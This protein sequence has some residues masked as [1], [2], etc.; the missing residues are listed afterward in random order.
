MSD[1]FIDVKGRITILPHNKMSGKVKVIAV[2]NDEISS[3]VNIKKPN[4][5]PSSVSIYSDNV[6]INP[7]FPPTFGSQKKANVSI[8]H[9]NE[10]RSNIKINAK[11]RMTG[12]VDITPPPKKTIKLFPV[13]DAFVRE[14]IPTLNYGTEQSMAVGYNS[15]FNESY[16]ALIQFDI[17][18]LPKDIII[19]KA[20]VNLFS[21]EIKKTSQQLGIFTLQAEWNEIGVTWNNQPNISDLLDIQN[22]KDGKISFDITNETKNW[23]D[24]SVSNNGLEIKAVNET[25]NEYVQFNTRENPIDK[26]YLEITYRDKTI[27][28]FGRSEV[29]SKVFIYAVGKSDLKASVRIKSFDEAS[30]I[31]AKVHILNPMFME[32]NVVISKPDL[33]SNVTIRQSGESTISGNVTIR[34]KFFSNLRSS[35]SINAPDR[36]GRVTIPYRSQVNGNVVIRG[37][38]KHDIPAKISISRDTVYASLQIRQKGTNEVTAS[39]TINRGEYRD[40][41]ANVGISQPEIKGNVQIVHSSYMPSSVLIRQNVNSDISSVVV[42]PH[43]KDILG[44]VE[45]VGASMIPSSVY[46]NSEFIRA[47]V[48]IPAYQTNDIRGKVTIRVK[49]ISDLRCSLHI[50]GDNVLG[51]YVYIL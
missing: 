12:V 24:G 23:H 28:S 38:D 50:G 1:V 37:Y 16:R 43:R 47:N 10:I 11:N 27:Y 32:S 9:R 39:V 8:L 42:I 48:R 46:I 45:I 6:I 29:L 26:P 17:S 33:V 31:P 49:W 51:G 36:I 22:V 4:D 19:D 21:S 18:S 35:I 44:S 7:M 13:Q 14:G 3:S 5:L 30:I 15:P 2:G 41:K 20:S 40:I 34:Q 25:V